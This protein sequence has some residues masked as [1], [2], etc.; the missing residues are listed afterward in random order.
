MNCV[1]GQ[2][3]Y[4]RWKDVKS[5]EYKYFKSVLVFECALGESVSYPFIDDHKK[6]LAV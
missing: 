3:K 4:V 2:C 6:R 5:D 1:S